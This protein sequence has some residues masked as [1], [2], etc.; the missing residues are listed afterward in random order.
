MIVK[1][2][3]KKKS[4]LYPKRAKLQIGEDRVLLERGTKERKMKLREKLTCLEIKR[5]LSALS[6]SLGMK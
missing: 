2:S 4:M 5:R 6:D 3:P 1:E